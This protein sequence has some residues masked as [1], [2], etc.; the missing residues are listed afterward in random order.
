MEKQQL[1]EINPLWRDDARVDI[2]ISKLRRTI[3]EW[4]RLTGMAK[5]VLINGCASH[6]VST[7]RIYIPDF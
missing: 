7:I 3:V 2:G 5:L 1:S 6:A 4:I